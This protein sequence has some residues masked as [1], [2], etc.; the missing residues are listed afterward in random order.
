MNI[1]VMLFNAPTIKRA[2]DLWWAPKLIILTYFGAKTKVLF[3][4]VPLIN[5]PLNLLKN[6]REPWE[7][8]LTTVVGG[9]SRDA[10]GCACAACAGGM[11]A[12]GAQLSIPAT[13]E[14]SCRLMLASFGVRILSYKGVS[15]KVQ[16]GT[17]NFATKI[18]ILWVEKNKEKNVT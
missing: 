15:C 9:C 7:L 1:I 18:Y 2:W 4:I 12:G 16:I 3:E 6:S 8:I 11:P 14:T 10:Q 13:K 5:I 17:Y